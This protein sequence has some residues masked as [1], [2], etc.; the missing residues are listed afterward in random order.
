M[1]YFIFWFALDS[2][3]WSLSL[4]LMILIKLVVLM[5]ES[6]L[7]VMVMIFFLVE[8]WSLINITNNTLLLDLLYRQSIKSLVKLL[9][10]YNGSSLYFLNLKILVQL[11]FYD[12]ITYKP[13]IWQLVQFSYLH[14][15][16]RDWFSFCPWHHH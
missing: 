10:N 6:L 9:Q 15:T 12:M 14:E 2:S 11:I 4:S 8:N 13:F 1:W 7:V 3:K 16:C 5:I